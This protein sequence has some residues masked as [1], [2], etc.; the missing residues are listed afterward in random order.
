M[1]H[2]IQTSKHHR[3]YVHSAFKTHQFSHHHP[4]Q[5]FSTRP[6]QYKNW[7]EDRMRKAVK[8]VRDGASIRR[9]AEEYAIPRATLH[10]RVVGRVQPGSKSGPRKYLDSL[11]EEELVTFLRNCS[12]IGYGKTRKETLALVQGA[13]EKKGINTQ[14]SESW[15][16]SF[17]KRHP[18]L[19]LKTGESISRARQIGASVE[20]LQNYFDILEQ[21][22][23]DN[24]LIH[25][26]CQIF[27]ADE[28]GV[29]L[30]AKPLKVFGTKSQKNFYS[31]ST[32]N[33]AQVTVLAC[34]SAGGTSLPPMIIFNRKGLGDGMDEDSVP[35]T[36][37]AFS[38]KGWIDTELFEN[39][40]FHHFLVYAPPVRPLL[41]LLDGHSSHYSP[42]L[43]NKAA[44][45][46]VIV[47]CL[48]PNTTHRTQ[49]LD[50]GA[51]SPL[52]RYW[53]E[54]CHN[55]LC[56]NP[57]KVITHY[58]FGAIFSKAWAQAMTPSN[59]MA[60]FKITGVY[61]VNCFA[62]VPP[63]TAPKLTLCERTG[64]KYIPFC[65]PKKSRL[66]LSVE[67]QQLPQTPFLSSE[68]EIE[69]CDEI[70]TDSI[71][72]ITS[73]NEVMS[74]DE[75][76]TQE[77]VLRFTK[78]FEE[79]YDIKS[80]KRYNAWL[81]HKSPSK[82]KPRTALSEFLTLPEIK[83]PDTTQHKPSARI[84]ISEEHRIRLIEKE[85]KKKEDAERKAFNKAEREQK[86]VEREI[87]RRE[88]EARKRLNEQKKGKFLNLDY[89]CVSDVILHFIIARYLLCLN[90]VS[91]V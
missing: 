4:G 40:F 7:T 15:L 53:R 5:Q 65:T 86:R 52:K 17:S 35:G 12:S 69:K 22:L 66:S 1:A 44:E 68:S 34:V 6:E 80:D 72:Y 64:L 77:E 36:L 78:R 60:G 87:K 88:I 76:F 38:P 57:G 26:P 14:V 37:F 79:G 82:V 50:K 9:A 20:S 75:P 13:V 43:V 18:D 91:I 58:Q 27:N 61:P 11:E 85:R 71:N 67:H 8:A 70:S 55:F 25:R 56:A 74:D 47:F 41:L 46:K 45:E 16:K 24:D 31:V 59:I 63:E 42:Q 90:Y 32:G 10:D 54:E 23:Y 84:I 89:I 48:P 81:K 28:T 51:F 21:T 19:T 39:W 49:P 3:I 33:K 73:D 83:Y 2:S 62:L 30:D 29:P